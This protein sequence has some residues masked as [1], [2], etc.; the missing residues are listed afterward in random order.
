MALIFLYKLYKNGDRVGRSLFS[1]QFGG[2]LVESTPQN[3]TPPRRG[4]RACGACS[5]AAPT[6]ACRPAGRGKWRRREGRCSLSE[7]H[8]LPNRAVTLLLRQVGS[9]NGKRGGF[10]RGRLQS[11]RCS[12]AGSP[13]V[14]SAPTSPSRVREH[15]A[16]TLLHDPKGFSR[17]TFILRKTPHFGSWTLLNTDSKTKGKMNPNQNVAELV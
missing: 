1:V 9:A 7:T 11:A 13:I 4:G 6:D 15:R 10:S 12:E 2:A 17:T 3:R 5:P 14:L 16:Y 8:G